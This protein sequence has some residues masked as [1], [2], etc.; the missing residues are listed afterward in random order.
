MIQKSNPFNI[1]EARSGSQ[2]MGSLASF[3]G[4]S[5]I[6]IMGENAK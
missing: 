2:A 1:V 4:S 6:T 5:K 3:L